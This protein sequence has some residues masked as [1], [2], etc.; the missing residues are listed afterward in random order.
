LET[1][2]SSS[3]KP[4]FERIT[5]AEGLSFPV[6]RDIL[7][8]QEGFLW[9]ATDSGLNRY[10][11]YNFTV[12]REALDDPGTIRFDD[13]WV[14]LE[15]SDGVLWVGGGGGLDRLE[16]ETGTF[17]H[18]DTRGQVFA[19][20]EDSVGTLWAGFWHGLYGYDRSTNE[21]IHSEQPQPDAPQNWAAR[22]E[23]A[24]RAILEDQSGGLWIGTDTGLYRLD[25]RTRAL[26][27][28]F[29]HDARDPASLG[30]DFVNALYEDRGGNL[31][32]GTRGGG[33]DHY[34][35]SSGAFVHYRHD[36]GDATSL[37]DPNVLS[38]LEDNAGRLWLGTVS[39][40]DRVDSTVAAPGSATTQ[41]TGRTRFLHFRHDP[42]DPLSLSQ[43]TVTSLYQDRSGIIWVG[44]GNGVSKYTGRE[45]QF[46]HYR[47]LLDPPETSAY[48]LDVSNLLAGPLPAI[49]SDSMI[50]AIHGDEDGTLWIG[51]GAGGLNYLDR[52]AGELQVYRHDPEDPD[53]LSSDHVGSVYRDQEGALWVGTGSGWLEE[54]DPLTGSF[55]HR[56]HLGDGVTAIAE[57]GK[58]FLWIGT[59]GDGLYRLDQSRTSLVHYQQYWQ[60]PDHWHRE[61]SLSSHIVSTLNADPFGV[62]WAGTVYGGINLWGDVPDR[63]THF[64]HDP[65]D[66]TSVS[67]DQVLSILDD[68]VAGV[69][70]VGTGGGGLNRFDRATE[71][72]TH[73]GE[74]QGLTSNTIGCIVVDRHGFL[75]LGTVRGLSRFDPRTE[76]FRNYDRRDGVG[77]LSAGQVEPGSCY[78][79]QNGE[80]VFGGADGLYAFYPV[81]IAENLHPP[82]VAITALKIFNSALL[83][84]PRPGEEIRLPYQ[85]NFV[86]FEF[87][88]LDYTMPERNQYAY[89]LE[90]LDRDWVYAGAR[91]FADYPDLKP[92]DY[93]FRVKA[94]NSDGVWNEEGVALRISVATPIWE[95]WAFRVLAILALILIGVGIYRQRLGGI[96]A[97]GRELERQV[98]ERTREIQRLHEKTQELAVTEERQRLARDLHDAVSQTLFSAS[99]IAEAL[100]DVWKSSPDEGK[101]LLEKLRQL[102]RGALAEMRALLMELRPATLVEASMRDLLRQLGQ[103]VSGREGI[104][105]TVTVDEPCDL[106]AD[107]QVALYRIAQEALNNVVKHAQANQVEVSLRCV[108][109]SFP[110]SNQDAD[111]RDVTVELCIRDDG[112]GFDP[113][114]V[115]PEH[116]GL[117][118]MRERSEAIGAMLKIDSLEGQGTEVFLAW[119]DEV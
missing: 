57:D 82:P 24:V 35:G 32:I 74:E 11:G 97:R 108:A 93:V 119:S 85:D 4:R 44:T 89:M 91:R 30:S 47:K 22:T 28:H 76:S 96:E 9:F 73:Y 98:D 112:I 21:L 80:I 52:Q 16:R 41:A 34:D 59:H 113:A 46:A 88:A 42:D 111:G 43:N 17:T 83:G 40:L 60:D 86:S 77:V 71:T 49:L 6:I 26:S 103:A 10:D 39:G 62:L 81:Q 19:L 110:T 38:I 65:A 87:A 68:P 101:D 7:Q 67:H 92:G 33:L 99:L 114:C 107:V 109:R 95:T 5:T 106:P 15:D 8:D 64:R 48:R 37:G 100:P 50:T 94:S 51:T 84:E 58:G 72:F 53:S 118:I 14:L 25:A 115:S 27:H 13:V 20:Y 18:V 12:Y 61:G 1:Q 102:S 31:W 2:S 105:V 45:G 54:F 75:W 78:Q 117:G 3:A 69:V 70:W 29:R 90:G 116:L 63:F 55:A 56:Y 23:S 66:S 36:P 79:S 104:P